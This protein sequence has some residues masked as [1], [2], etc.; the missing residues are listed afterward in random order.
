MENWIMP[1]HPGR[2]YGLPGSLE[3]K[4][5]IRTIRN[6]P[7]AVELTLDRI[8]LGDS[9]LTAIR[10]LMLSRKW[11]SITMHHCSE[12][13]DEVIESALEHAVRL[14][15]RGGVD[16]SIAVAVSSGLR[17]GNCYTRKL[18]LNGA[19]IAIETAAALG[20]G[21]S[22]SQALEEFALT[23]CRVNSD[24][25]AA[26]LAETTR[27]RA[28]YLCDCHLEDDNIAQIA[29]ALGHHPLLKQLWLNG[30]QNFCQGGAE[31]LLEGL[32]THMEL[33]HLQL[34]PRSFDCRPQ[35][36]VYMDLNRGGRRL[37]GESNAPLALWP[38][39]LERAGRI[40]GMNEQSRANI[41][42]F[43]VRQLHGR[44]RLRR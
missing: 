13:I 20:E 42:Y 44:E 31:H 21:L 30:Q 39:V 26:L 19:K 35:I 2:I 40:P 7:N 5:S 32:K 24:I 41:I 43:F 17:S 14:E 38:R 8:E 10:R 29:R 18:C 3:L 36:Q 34:P 16:H 22:A 28:I 25:L 12:R 11:K 15:L 4:R 9:T 1:P 27:L 37:L 23:N 33:E 6:D